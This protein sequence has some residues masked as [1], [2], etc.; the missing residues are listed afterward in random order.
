MIIK[1]VVICLGYT[2]LT[3]TILFDAKHTTTNFDVKKKSTV[4]D[5]MTTVL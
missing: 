1:I 2:G 5:L 3:L 4:Y